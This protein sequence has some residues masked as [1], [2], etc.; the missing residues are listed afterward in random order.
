[1]TSQ[2]ED[3]AKV[4][5][6]SLRTAGG[7]VWQDETLKEWPE[8]DFRMWVGNLGSEVNPSVLKLT[9]SKKYPSVAMARVVYDKRTGKSKGFGFVSFLDYRDC[10]QALRTMNGTFIGS[11]PVML[12]TSK[13][14]DRNTSKKKL[15][16]SGIGGGGNGRKRR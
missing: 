10:A 4:K 12:K 8:N 13:W 9:F 15:R 1:M 6:T 11:Q 7:E 14:K 5:K 2:Q 16:K 3:T